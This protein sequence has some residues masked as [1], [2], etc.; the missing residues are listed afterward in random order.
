M[1]KTMQ[2]IVSETHQRL[3]TLVARGQADQDALGAQLSLD[4]RAAHGEL[5]VWSPKDQVAHNNFWRQDAIRRLQAALDGGTPVE[6]D[7]EQALNDRIFAEQYT[8]SWEV[9]V[10]ETER[11][12]LETINGI[13]RLDAGDLTMIDRYPWQ[14]GK[15]LERMLVTNWYEHP[16]EHW[17]DI[18]LSRHDVERAIALR[19]EVANTVRDL[20]AHDPIL[21]SYVIYNLGGF[22]TRI[23]HVEP[24]M[25]AIH[26]ALAA[27]H[28]LLEWARQDTELDPLRA[29]PAFQALM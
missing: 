11:L 13:G 24:A 15:S 7:D 22:Y 19:Q 5:S 1:G 18:Y 28:A 8:T 26:E 20:F 2:P 10:A 12:R 14:R 27:N 4:E 9:L 23:G 6:E 21:Y 16:A 17:A 3:I 25:H 29:L